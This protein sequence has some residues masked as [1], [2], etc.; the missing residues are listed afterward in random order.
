MNTKYI[1]KDAN[2]KIVILIIIIYFL[3]VSFVAF[4]LNP[5]L[6]NEDVVSYYFTGQQIIEGN[7][8]DTLSPDTP[9]H[10]PRSRGQGP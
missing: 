4:N 1:F 3:A 8:K 10:P 7:A 9:F 5:F 6:T 2:T